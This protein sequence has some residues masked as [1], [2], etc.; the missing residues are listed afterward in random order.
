MAA[1]WPDLTRLR[2]CCE[3][4]DGNAGFAA[5]TGLRELRLQPFKWDAWS[6]E[7]PILLWPAQLP[8]SLTCFEGS[9]V[10][11]LEQAC[12]GSS[13]AGPSNAAHDDGAA[14]GSSE[15]EALA[16][17]LLQR[18][19]LRSVS[20]VERALRLPDLSQLHRV[21]SLELS[22]SQL[23]HEH[24]GHIVAHLSGTLTSLKLAAVGDGRC[25]KNSALA[26][27]TR[28]HK[29]STLHLA[30]Y[31]QALDRHVRGALVTMRQLR[32]LT[33]CTCSRN[34]AQTAKSLQVGRVVSMAASCMRC[35]WYMVVHGHLLAV[36][37]SC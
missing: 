26:Q 20:P 19:V 2:L 31:E 5:L 28:L 34:P 12:P 35:S 27:L 32:T 13:Q 1:A 9:D 29:L 23:S 22:H 15:V 17:P 3:L 10:W 25:I 30:V 24:I 36:D 21:E 16:L 18:L 8:A 11:C 14:S 7:P 6:S 4:Q 33:L 37:E